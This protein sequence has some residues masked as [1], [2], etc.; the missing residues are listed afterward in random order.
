MSKRAFVKDRSTKRSAKL[1][2]QL[3]A[4]KAARAAARAATGPSQME[5]E[6]AVKKAVMKEKSKDA[7]FVDRAV[8]TFAC[9]TTGTIVLAA[10]VAQ[11]V[12]VNQRVGKKAVWKSCQLR[13]NVTAGASGTVAEAA[14]MLV[15]DR[16][17]TNALPAITDILVTANSNAFLNDVNSDRFQIVRRW[18]WILQGN[19]TTPA[20]GAESFPV[21]E[22]IDLKKR[23]VEFNAAATGAIGDI[24]KGALYF[25]SVGTLAAGATAPSLVMG[26]RTRFIDVEG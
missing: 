26:N 6:M 4:A 23:P 8:S 24:A 9:D 15:Y 12:S 18:D 17:P 14:L 3:A 1:E 25:V 7:G 5:F 20:T 2:A 19:S 11:G 21:D 10:T 16:K 13:G 22:Y